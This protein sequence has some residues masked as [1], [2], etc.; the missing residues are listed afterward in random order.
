MARRTVL[1]GTVLALGLVSPARADPPIDDTLAGY[2]QALAERPHDVA[3][4]CQRADL[5]ERS[6]EPARALEDVRLALALHPDEP[7]ALVLEGRALAAL[8]RIDEA[9]TSLDR[10][11]AIAPESFAA[12]RTRADLRA[13]RGDLRG[14]I[15]DLDAALRLSDDVDAYL[16]RAHWLVRDGRAAE[17]AEGLEQALAR[18]EGSAP[19]VLAAIDAHLAAGAPA[20]ALDLVDAAI[21]RTPTDPRL[22]LLRADV[23]ARMGRSA[24]AARAAS[25]ALERIDER[26]AHRRTAALLV[27]RGEALLRLGRI[28]EAR[29]ALASAQEIEPRYPR[30]LALG[31]RLSE[32]SR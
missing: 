1:L 25:D 30:A 32:V 12:R 8:D 14:A 20:P 7:S 21:A 2:A 26:L 18:T 23:L 16:D 3:L 29:T 15:E 28:D 5:L 11:I 22:G 24:D 31:A 9:M 6:G 27:D 4:L 17:A 19:L 10:A 13:A